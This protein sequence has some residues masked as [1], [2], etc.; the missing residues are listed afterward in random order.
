V[1]NTTSSNSPPNSPLLVLVSL[2]I[3]L[4]L[5]VLVVYF[6]DI[7]EQPALK[8]VQ[9]VTG[10][11]AP[12]SGEDLPS[13]G[14]ATAIVSAVMHDMGYEPRYQFISWGVAIDRIKSSKTDDEIRGGFPFYD[15]NER[16][17]IFYYTD[18]VMTVQM[19][20][21]YNKTTN[22]EAATVK[23]VADLSRLNVLKIAGY[24]YPESIRQYLTGNPETTEPTIDAAFMRIANSADAE[25][26]VFIESL[27]VGNQLLEEKYPELV[28]KISSAPLDEGKPTPLYFILSKNNPNNSTLMIDFNRGLQRLK[29]NGSFITLQ[30]SVQRK[31]DMER[32]VQ[33]VPVDG[34]GIV[35]AYTDAS[36]QNSTILPNGSRAIVKQWDAQFFQESTQSNS[37]T[38]TLVR[39]KLLNG[40][41]KNRE[42]IVDGR[43]IK[44]Q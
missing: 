25:N 24:D 21:F 1:A 42:F 41:M 26:I 20:I 6:Y 28:S 3:P 5:M 30:K 11:W 10:E 29:N 23:S 12:Y 17:K 32:S 8:P 36:K 16:R 7:G 39:I 38:N 4:I 33:L 14:A 2:G 9:L 27:E 35:R 22:P 40:P 34:Q 19:G 37:P 31:I 43:A 13:N 44:L 15:N 18:P